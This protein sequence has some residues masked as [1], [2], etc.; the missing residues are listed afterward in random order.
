MFGL[1]SLS[2]AAAAGAGAA[3]LATPPHVASRVLLAQPWVLHLTL[4]LSLGTLLLLALSERLRRPHPHSLL[5]FAGEPTR[6][7]EQLRIAGCPETRH[8]VA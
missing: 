4:V 1:L 3:V 5:A 7:C 6:S 2:L 8:R